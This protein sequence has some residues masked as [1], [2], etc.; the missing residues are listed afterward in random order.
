MNVW[1]HSVSSQLKFGGTPEDYQPIHSFLDSSK[2]YFYHLKHRALL[3]NLYGIELCEELFGSWIT[4]SSGTRVPVRDIAAQ[5][6]REDLSGRVPTL[7]DWF[8]TSE[9]HFS[10]RIIVP[11]IEHHELREFVL[12]P[13]L[14][15]GLRSSLMITCSNFGVSLVQRCLGLTHALELAGLLTPLPSVDTFLAEFKFVER[16]QYTPDRQSIERIND[17]EEK[18]EEQPLENDTFEPSVVRPQGHV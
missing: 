16:W 8:T 1:K 11:E 6:C 14:R 12:R 9:A 15:S 5:H 17:R 4:N 13:W 2:L 3:H 7:N 18:R 10:S